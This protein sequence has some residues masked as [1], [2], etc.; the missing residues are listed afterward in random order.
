MLLLTLV[1]ELA[2]VVLVGAA[3]SVILVVVVDVVA[4]AVVLIQIWG[5]EK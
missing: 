3:A 5:V 2:R 4:V 1:D